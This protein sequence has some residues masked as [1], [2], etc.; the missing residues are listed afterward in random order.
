MLQTNIRQSQTL[1]IGC[2]GAVNFCNFAKC[3]CFHFINFFNSLISSNITL[4]NRAKRSSVTDG[5]S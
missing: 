5:F 2:D 4:S 1:V 3:N